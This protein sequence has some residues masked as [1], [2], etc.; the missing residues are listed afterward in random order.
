[1]K[2]AVVGAGAMGSLYG[3]YLSQNNEVFLID[4]WKEH[5]EAI[6]S[7][8]LVIEEAGESQHIYH[9]K[10]AASSASVGIADLVLLF[11]KSIQTEQALRDNISLIGPKTVLL[12]LQ[13]GLGNDEDMRKFVGPE[14]ILIGTTSHGST[15]KQ[16]GYICHRGFGATH[17]GPL[18]DEN[19]QTADIVRVFNDAGFE[20]VLSDNIMNLVWS[21]LFVN[22]GINAITA[23]LCQTNSCINTGEY[24]NHAARKAVFEAVGV[25]NAAGMSFDAE[26]VFRNVCDIAEKTGQN[27]SSMLA[28]VINR[29]ETEIDKINGA[30]VHKARQLGLEAPFNELL[31]CLVKAKKD[32]VPLS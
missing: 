24:A 12:S 1:M 19:A 28:D 31:T 8:G 4:I 22:I 21:K 3:G 32:T 25:A 7:R 16:P 5:I 14:Q 20:T 17:L 23:L 18:A 2:I 15:M 10:A 29:R 30:V 11:V 26:A 6:Q 9:P 27:R 13:N